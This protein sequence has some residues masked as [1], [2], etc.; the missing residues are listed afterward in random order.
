M[1]CRRHSK[2]PSRTDKE[3][4]L[5]MAHTPSSQVYST[6]FE[7][8]PMLMGSEMALKTIEME[9]NDGPVCLILHLSSPSFHCSIILITSSL[10]PTTTT[11]T[12]ALIP[13]PSPSTAL[14]HHRRRRLQQQQQQ[15]DKATTTNHHI[16]EEEKQQHG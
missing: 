5:T 3:N 2:F 4:N 12:T 8:M 9:N 10:S 13:S 6:I 7:V 1:C 15:T 14:P 16:K 11:T